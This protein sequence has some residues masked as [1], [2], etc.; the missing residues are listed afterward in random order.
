MPARP[1]SACVCIVERRDATW[2][3][4]QVQAGAVFTQRQRW[5]LDQITDVIATSAGISANDLDNAL[6]AE[7]GGVDGALRAALVTTSG[8]TWKRSTPS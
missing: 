5:R 7:R 4:Q 8:P 1:V 2:L 6:F 3:A